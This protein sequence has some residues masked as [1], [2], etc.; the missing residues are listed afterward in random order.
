MVAPTGVTVTVVLLRAVTFQVEPELVLQS[1]VQ[2]A[3]AV[4][5]AVV[6]L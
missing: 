2:L 4:M 6:S 5:V 3:A 1:T